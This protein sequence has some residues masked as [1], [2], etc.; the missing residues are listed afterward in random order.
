MRKTL[1]GITAALLAAI[2]AFQAIPITMA[3]DTESEG[4]NPYEGITDFDETELDPGLLEESVSV[5]ETSPVVLG[6]EVSLRTENSK[7]F[8]MSDGSY[9]AA[10]YPIQV[11][12]ESDGV[13]K[14]IDNTPK[15]V[16][17]NGVQVLRADSG[18][19]YR[20]LPFRRQIV[21]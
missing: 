14:E 11:H 1:C 16:Y 21:Q 10:V 6:E 4:Y 18:E 15:T 13:M 20:F 17:E 2:I 8:R 3:A 12:Y 7:F 5:S 19:A 9:T